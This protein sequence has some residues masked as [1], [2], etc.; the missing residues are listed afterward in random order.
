L[1][2]VVKFRWEFTPKEYARVF[3]VC[4]LLF[5]GAR[6]VL[7]AA[8]LCMLALLGGVASAALASPRADVISGQPAAASG[9]ATMRWSF[10]VHVVRLGDNS[11]PARMPST[12]PVDEPARDAM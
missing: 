4:T 9:P 2:R 7:R 5:A 1:S 3:D 10:R 6:D 11:T 8:G 12:T